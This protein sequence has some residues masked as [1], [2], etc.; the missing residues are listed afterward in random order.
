MS[1]GGV[2]RRIIHNSNFMKAVIYTKYGPPEVLKIEDVE[3]P[4]PKDNE[5]LIKIY[6]T[7]VSSGDVK[8]RSFSDIP[9][10]PWIPFRLAVGL[11]RPRKKILG[12]TLAGEV[13]SIGK[14]IKKYKVGDKIF[15]SAGFGG[16]TYAQ[17]RCV[18]ENE[19]ITKKPE[20]MTYEEAVTIPFGGMTSLFFLKKGGIKA[21]QKVLVYGASG[22][23]GT[24]A[25][26]IAK[27]FGAEVTG[28]CSGVNVEL[29]KSLGADKV[30]NYK[31]EDFTK[32]GESYDIIFDTVGKTHFSNSVKSLNKKGFYL[33]AL[34]LEAKPILQGIWTN[35]TSDKKI[36]GGVAKETI[37]DLDFLKEL[38]EKGEYRAVVDK[39][40]P[41]EEI[42]KA[43]KHV[44]T[45]RKKGNVVITIG[46]E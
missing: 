39:I 41:L 5:I 35:I 27:F 43:H 44:E 24:A 26:Q 36:V 6:A 31:E 3:K 37:E 12:F 23:L 4:V 2:R 11:F 40:Y 22:A 34:H 21:G 1:G 9:P 17:Y 10:L 16:G 25:I 15:G 18:V 46:H 30:I 14:N 32:N 33:R 38:F 20:R 13:E 19:I 8:I 29:V 45:G 42:V 7:S 28:V